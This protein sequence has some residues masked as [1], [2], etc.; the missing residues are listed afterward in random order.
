MSGHRAKRAAAKL[1]FEVATAQHARQSLGPTRPASPVASS[2]TAMATEATVSPPLDSITH[3]ENILESIVLDPAIALKFHNRPN[4][5][6]CSVHSLPAFVPSLTSAPCNDRIATALATLEKQ[7]V[8]LKKRKFDPQSDEALSTDILLTQIHDKQEEI[9]HFLRLM[10][11]R[12]RLV[13]KGQLVVYT[14][15]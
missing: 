14:G 1:S 8:A 10:W 2:V 15:K 6:Q 5:S 7:E 9:R 4:A 11:E 13:T 3:I 12:D